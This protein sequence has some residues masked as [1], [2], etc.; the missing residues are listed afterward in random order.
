MKKFFATF[1]VIV[2]VGIFGC[3]ITGLVADNIKA[4]NIEKELADVEL[5]TGTTMVTSISRVGRLTVPNGP[6]QFYGAV[7]LQS[8]ESAGEL[9]SSFQSKYKGD[10]DYKLIPLEE[11]PEEFGTDFPKDLRF[12]YHDSAPKGYYMVYAFADGD[13]PF[14]YMDY[15]YYF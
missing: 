7:L 1:F 5:P 13:D 8:N 14:L 3:A 15:R 4:Q 12:N 10:L 6:I 11:A 2:I 9:L